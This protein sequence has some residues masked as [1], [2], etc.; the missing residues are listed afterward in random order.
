APFT[1]VNEET[2]W[3][4]DERTIRHPLVARMAPR[5]KRLLRE[6]TRPRA[7]RWSCPRRGTSLGEEQHA[8]R[9]IVAAVHMPLS[10]RRT[11]ARSCGVQPVDRLLGAPRA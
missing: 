6:R 8:P 7:I 11:E 10:R 2:T 3:A 4:R 1:S 5:A 9:P